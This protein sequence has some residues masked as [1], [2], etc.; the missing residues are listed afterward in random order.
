MDAHTPSK[1]TTSGSKYTLQKEQVVQGTWNKKE[2][3]K[4]KLGHIKELLVKKEKSQQ[5]VIIFSKNESEL[6][7]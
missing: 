6:K 3:N 2:R 4:I 1:H 7:S 5:K